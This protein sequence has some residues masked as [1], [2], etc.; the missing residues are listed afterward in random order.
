MR[1][2]G[3][4]STSGSSSPVSPTVAPYLL[5]PT[6]P[7]TTSGPP[8]SHLGRD[9]SSVVFLLYEQR[10]DDPRH[11]VGERDGYQHARFA[12]Q[13]LFEPRSLWRAAF[14]RLLHDGAAA[15]D[16]QAPERA[17]THFGCRAK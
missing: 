1:A 11:F 16:E 4:M 2:P 7:A 12:S 14:A 3:T 13:H 10:P 8:G 5:R 15:D 17:F 9:R 6:T